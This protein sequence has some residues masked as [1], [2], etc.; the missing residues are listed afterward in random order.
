MAAAAT[1]AYPTYAVWRAPLGVSV[2]VADGSDPS[3]SKAPVGTPVSADE[4]AA[5]LVDEDA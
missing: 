5:E 4:A 1:P 2:A 3:T